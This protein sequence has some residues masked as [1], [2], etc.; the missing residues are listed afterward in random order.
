MNEPRTTFD[1]Y[2]FFDDNISFLMN[3]KIYTHIKK[4]YSDTFSISSLDNTIS[5]SV[6]SLSEKAEETKAERLKTEEEKEKPGKKE[7]DI[8]KQVSTSSLNSPDDSE[9]KDITGLS[10]E[11]KQLKE[12]M[13]KQLVSQQVQRLYVA[14]MDFTIES[15]SKLESDS[16]MLD[17][18]ERYSMLFLG[19]VLQ[20]I[21]INYYDK[22]NIIAGVC[23][24]LERFE[25]EE[26]RP[27][28]QSIISGLINHPSIYVKERVISLIENWEDIS[29]L[30]LLR[31]I[32]IASEW[33]KNYIQ[34]VI[35]YL[36]EIK[37][38]M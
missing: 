28:G 13:Y 31:S 16:I 18:A 14:L 24:G 2:L 26:V 20:N 30:P 25:A 29:L 36:E 15:D 34:D 11:E 22:P 23:F 8:I 17:I 5:F 35:K 27:W 6:N 12:K 38:T 1:D 33:M 32:E 9:L 7:E 19:N 3:K 4:L 37:C 10:L 21:C